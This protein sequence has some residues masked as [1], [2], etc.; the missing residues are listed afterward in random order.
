MSQVME[1]S[2]TALSWLS[3]DGGSNNVRLTCTSAG[4]LNMSTSAANAYITGISTNSAVNTSVVTVGHL[5]DALLGRNAKN[6]VVAV[7]TDNVDLSG[8]LVV[9][10]VIDGVTLALNDRVLLVGQTD[11][12][13]NGIY[14]APAS[15]TASRSEDMNATKVRVKRVKFLAPS[16]GLVVVL[17]MLENSMLSLHLP[18]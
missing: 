15:G 17:P 16:C 2:T 5:N 6:A 8:G 10:T 9:G 18:S 12:T 13:E 3:S 11:S 1:A 4:T 14:L 7:S